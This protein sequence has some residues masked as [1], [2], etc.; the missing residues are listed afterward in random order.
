MAREACCVARVSSGRVRV[1]VGKVVRRD[2]SVA[3]CL[4][5]R[6]AESIWRV[7]GGA[8]GGGGDG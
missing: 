8:E 7:I 2:E 6:A 5:A 3:G 1:V 4:D